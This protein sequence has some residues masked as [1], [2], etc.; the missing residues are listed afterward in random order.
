MAVRRDSRVNC[1]VA[2]KG[3]GSRDVGGR[4][5]YT[6]NQKR[7]I[8]DDEG[9]SYGVSTE[10]HVLNMTPKGER[11]PRICVLT[12]TFYPIVGGG[13]VHARLLSEKLIERGSTVF[14]VTRRSLAR[15]E[16]KEHVGGIRVCRVAPAGFGRY[17]KYLMLLP[18][19][20][21]LV[22]MR[23]QYDVIYV[24]GLR[25]LGVVGVVGAVLLRKRCI[26]RAESSTE[27]SGHFYW[28]CE[29]VRNSKVLQNILHIFVRVRNKVLKK[30]DGFVSI[31]GPIR[32]EFLRCGIGLD[33]I[34]HIPNGINIEQFVLV[35]ENT[36][37]T[38]RKQLSLPAK[39]IFTYTGKL[40][41]GKGLNHLM[42]VWKRIVSE[43]ND[44]HLVL[45][46]SGGHQFLSCEDNLR[47]FAQEHGLQDYIT[48]TGYVGNVHEY[49]QCS[50]YF[51]L[52]SEM[53]GLPISLLEALSCGLPAI[54]TRA[55]GIVDIIK[56]G[57]GGILIEVGNEEQ[58]Y[59]G[60]MNFVK[61]P[62]K[63]KELGRKGRE[64]VCSQFDI[65]HVANTHLRLFSG[66]MAR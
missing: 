21:R 43:R 30:A 47:S 58:L 39:C 22:R 53:E 63:S 61:D 18:A 38:L 13:E 9:V 24:C 1:D 66:V 19:M 31:S 54:A 28:Q 36:R 64:I 6:S 34:T 7:G 11:V 16:K 52:P 12:E 2:V 29:D 15:L 60:I 5:H 26:L 41:R 49:L 20:L 55:G 50:D 37:V 14:V 32:N 3:D 25:V 23:N 56:N 8:D 51:I 48:F 40:I 62:T 46:G 45:V 4:L 35:D 42:K 59:E 33:Q 17:G 10:E 57:E 27:M 44:V 65:E